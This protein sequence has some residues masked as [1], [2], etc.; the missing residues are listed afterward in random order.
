MRRLAY[1]L[2]YGR[3]AWAGVAALLLAPLAACFRV[4]VAL[5]R[6]W[7]VPV[8]VDGLQVV[9]VGNLVV[10]GAGKTP[11]V[12]YLAQ[13][14]QRSGKRVAIL[15]RGYGRTSVEPVEFDAADLPPAVHVGDE[16]RLLA[17]RC[18]GVTLYVDG[19]RVA[20]AQRARAAG[21]SVAILDDGFQH[22]RLARDADVVVWSRVENRHVLPWGPL[23]EPVAALGRATVVL[24]RD[25]AVA[26]SSAAA[27]VPVTFAQRT[28]GGVEEGRCVL[29]T[30]IAR[31]ERVRADLEARGIVVVKHFEFPDHHPFHPVELEDV[32]EFS[33]RAQVPLVT[34]EK[35]A[36]R[37][38]PGFASVVVG[39][40]ARP[41]SEAKA[42]LAA[43]TGWPV[44]AAP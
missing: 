17:R 18:P 21:C 39:L 8:R 14:A 36:E 13:W 37:L 25:G 38:P 27:P 22:L 10:G 35:D 43:A 5:R 2:W 26:P 40:Q 15:S 32:R 19:D 11:L 24:S 12:E 34:T 41:S 9:S 42:A 23:R 7:L 20:A 30:G 3:P 6:A 1:A 4:A 16:P 33:T 29:V 31:S 44:E 28:S